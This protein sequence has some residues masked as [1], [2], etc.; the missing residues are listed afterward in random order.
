MSHFVYRGAAL[1]RADARVSALNALTSEAAAREFAGRI[2]VAADIV[3]GRFQH[4][5]HWA[6]S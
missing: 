4:D 5:G 1:L 6:H 2:G 3:V